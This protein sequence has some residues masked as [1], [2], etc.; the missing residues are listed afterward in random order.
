MHIWETNAG[1]SCAVLFVYDQLGPFLWGKNSA[2]AASGMP[3]DHDHDHMSSVASHERPPW[4]ADSWFLLASASLAAS[5]RC[6][7]PCTHRA[8]KHV[9]L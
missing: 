1:N 8:S 7:Q 4:S 3:H 2:Y 5:K 9:T 6:Q